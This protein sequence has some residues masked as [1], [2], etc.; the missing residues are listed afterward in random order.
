MTSLA[1]IRIGI[2]GAAGRMGQRLVVLGHQDPALK[3]VAC[4]EQ[5]SHAAQGHDAGRIAGI[6]ELGV[7]V[8]SGLETE[9]DVIIDFSVPA[10]VER[11]LA[12]CA[13]QSVPLVLATTGLDEMQQQQVQDAGKSIPIVYAPSMSLA[14]NLVMKLTQIA[15]ETLKNYEPGADVEIIERHHRFKEDA[16]SGTALGFGKIVADRMGQTQSAHGREGRPGARQFSEIGYHALRTGDNPGEHTIV[17]GMMGETVELTVR[18]TNR[19]CY[20]L[21][22]LAAAKYGVRQPAGI[23]SMND[24][25]GL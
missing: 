15:A 4:L 24:V 1:P 23:Y 21:G 9:V 7:P 20:A 18:A 13:Q 16:P 22:A 6:D 3:I 17:F 25:F 10:G 5:A 8:T 11:V 14:V 19:D 12:V 2:H